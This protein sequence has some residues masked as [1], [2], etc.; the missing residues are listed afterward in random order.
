MP[1]A[2]SSRIA[3]SERTCASPT[4]AASRSRSARHVGRRPQPHGGR[5]D[6]RGR[7]P[8]PT[9]RA[10]RAAAPRRSRPWPAPR[11]ARPIRGRPVRASRPGP[12]ASSG[13]DPR[14]RGDAG[15]GGSG[16][17]L[18]AACH[19]VERGVEL[20][21]GRPPQHGPPEPRPARRLL[22]S[23]SV[24][25]T[26]PA[27]GSSRASVTDEETIRANGEPGTISAQRRSRSGSE[28]SSVWSARTP[29]PPSRPSTTV[30]PPSPTPSTRRA[31]GHQR[32]SAY[33]SASTAQTAGAPA[34]SVRER[35][36][37]ISRR[38]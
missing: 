38:S 23:A 9:R 30:Q 26:V 7:R 31:S 21:L 15:I 4:A 32:G 3:S 8:R 18:D 2:R 10:R 34:R 25:V 5:R 12:A 14:R 19:A 13:G 29:R 6:R 36:T 11:P 33:G 35:T 24:I 27:P 1:A 16:S 22:L 20:A 37:R 17:S 28:A